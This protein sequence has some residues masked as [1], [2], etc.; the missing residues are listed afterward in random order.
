MDL[1]ADHSFK[2]LVSSYKILLVGVGGIGCE[3]LKQMVVSPFRQIEIVN[4][5]SNPG[6]S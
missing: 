4:H 6:R 1:L 2:T 5:M 3:F